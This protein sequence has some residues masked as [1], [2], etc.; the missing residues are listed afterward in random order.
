MHRYAS[1]VTINMNFFKHSPRDMTASVF[2]SVH[3]TPPTIFMY[4]NQRTYIAQSLRAG[5][6]L[7]VIILSCDHVDVS[8]F[9]PD[10]NGKV[11]RPYCLSPTDLP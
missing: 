1:G 4:V 9:A 2:L 10:A 3:T 6:R 7:G 5:G 8:T 11:Y